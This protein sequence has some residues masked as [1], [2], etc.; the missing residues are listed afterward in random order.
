MAAPV[1]PTGSAIESGVPRALFGLRLPGT[2]FNSAN[3]FG[4]NANTPY[5][6]LAA[7]DGQRF[8]VSEDAPPPVGE[9]PLTVVVNWTAGLKPSSPQSR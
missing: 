4:A 8:L 9:T 1:N 7:S 5:P 2:I 6:Y 3:A